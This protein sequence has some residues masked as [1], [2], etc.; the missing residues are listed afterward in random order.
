MYTTD[1]YYYHIAD[2]RTTGDL[3]WWPEETETETLADSIDNLTAG[4]PELDAESGD[5][6]KGIIAV[7]EIKRGGRNG[8]TVVTLAY[9][10]KEE[11]TTYGIK[12][13]IFLLS[14]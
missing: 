4:A 12:A 9:C 1:V 6:A 8:K 11:A 3:G 14:E 10:T 7:Y 2:G 13:D 5:Y